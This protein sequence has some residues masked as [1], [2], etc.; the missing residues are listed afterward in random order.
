MGLGRVLS[1]SS[2]PT[3]GV[4]PGLQILQSVRTYSESGLNNQASTSSK[5]IVIAETPF[6]T[7]CVRSIQALNRRTGK[8]TITVES[9]KHEFS[10]CQET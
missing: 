9:A 2:D 10:R 3:R 6:S 4:Y 5:R 8:L 7:A 1:Y